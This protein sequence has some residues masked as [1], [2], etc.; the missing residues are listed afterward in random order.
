MFTIRIQE[1]AN[2]YRLTTSFT[3]KFTDDK[4]S[5]E[6]DTVLLV[7]DGVI[8]NK[9]FFQN[10]YA[11]CKTWAEVVF[12]LYE[13][14]GETFFDLFN[15]SF[16]GIIYD[17]I[18]NT[19][20]VYSDHI[21]SKAIYYARI[22]D[23]YYCASSIESIYCFFQQQSIS[24]T[25]D[26]SAAYEMLVY[27]Y[28]LENHTLCNEIRKLEPGTYL[29]IRNGKAEVQTYFTIDNTPDDAR[30]ENEW[31]N[32]IDETFE[33]AIRMEFEKD[34]EYGY[35]HIVTLSGGLDSRMVSWVAHDMGYSEQLNI[36]LSQNDWLD[37]S[38]AKKIASDLQHDWMFKS[39]D[40]GLFLF[41][42]DEAIRIGEGQIQYMGLAH[43]NSMF[44]YLNFDTFGMLHSGVL[45]DVILGTYS[46]TDKVQQP[47]H[48]LVEKVAR[49]NLT[50]KL[51]SVQKQYPNQELVIF[52]Q[53]GLNGINT[54]LRTFQKYTETMSPF[55]NMEFLQLCF[56]IPLHLRFEHYLYKKWIIAKHPLAA[57][58]VWEKIRCKITRS[59]IPVSYKGKRFYLSQ[60]PELVTNRISKSI[61]K[62][63][64]AP[65]KT[66]MNP[67]DYYLDT[68]KTLALFFENYFKNNIDLIN[69][70]ELKCDM[71]S[72]FK[73]KTCYAADKIKV[74]SLLS[75]VKI[76]KLSNN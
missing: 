38:I 19:W 71:E 16:S 36:T 12:R 33:N 39:L 30:T 57:N 48:K 34:R 46:T 53:R 8:L 76:F 29:R 18:K 9:R 27:G 52:T 69:E 10:K 32:L 54:G 68:N 51:K 59:P 11:D 62:T 14:H 6:N 47:N 72:I 74:L 73:N 3:K 17:K 2:S 40:N 64:F 25:L 21:G 55:Y 20:I 5:F 15:G 26:V 65:V 13:T 28:L 35:Q 50:N 23:G 70:G 63:T 66:G 58:Y 37:E 4:F 56:K 75:A 49:H 41:D 45:G 42:I 61:K 24:Y 22:N 43:A 31:I 1:K 67:L 44:K 60:L 7:L